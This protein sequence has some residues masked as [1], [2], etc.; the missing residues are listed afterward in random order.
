MLRVETKPQ[1]FQK[2]VSVRRAMARDLEGILGIA[3]S[4]GTDYKDSEQGFLVDD[5]LNDR[6][7]MRKKMKRSLATLAYFYVAEIAGA[8]V[9]F[10]MAY[11]KD[12]WLAENPDWIEAV[13]WH[14]GFYM[15]SLQEFLV[16]DKTAV[17]GD[18]T[19]KGIG[20]LLYRELIGDLKG[21]NIKLLLA[22]T[23]I[24]PIPNFASLNFRKKQ[25]YQLAGMRYEF[26]NSKIYTDLIYYKNI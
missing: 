8:P 20:S 25:R 23:I 4:V 11:K 14:P 26:Y 15:E 6:G 5:Y 9:G 7:A 18:L 1:D 17:R 22:E 10:L 12:E 13:Q 21:S 19:G 24:D 16:V 2:V 3:S